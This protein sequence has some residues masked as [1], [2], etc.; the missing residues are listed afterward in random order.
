MKVFLHSCGQNWAIV[1]DLLDV[2]VDV[3]QFDQPTL[4][5]MPKLA[6]T[7]RERRAALCSPVDIQ[8]ILPT[9][10]RAV[11]EAGAREMYDIFEG[12][13]ICKNYLDL[14]GIGVR[15][16]WDQW[17]YEAICQRAGLEPLGATS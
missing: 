2:G 11:I 16:E 15:P 4:Y 13:L 14:P 1:P 12:G 7:L 10:D 5:D 17:A 8:K 9:G 3:F 6:A